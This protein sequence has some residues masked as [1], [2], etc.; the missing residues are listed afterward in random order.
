[1]KLERDIKYVNMKHEITVGKRIENEVGEKRD[2]E[3][4]R[5]F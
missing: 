1:M 4:N 5:E 2:E 3:R